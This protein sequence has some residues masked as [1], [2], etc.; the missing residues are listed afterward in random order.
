[1]RRAF[2]H[3]AQSIK[4]INWLRFMAIYRKMIQNRD[5]WVDVHSVNELDEHGQQ[6]RSSVMVWYRIDPVGVEA[7]FVPIKGTYVKDADAR[8]RPFET[9]EQA[10]DA[11]F[12]EAARVLQNR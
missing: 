4:I 3:Y 10:R 6:I 5:V 11:G 1:M 12:L 2:R 8:P 7:G 9:E